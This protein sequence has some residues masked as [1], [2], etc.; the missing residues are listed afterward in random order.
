MRTVY[1]NIDNN[2]DLIEGFGYYSPLTLMAYDDGGLV[3]IKL[4]ETNINI[5][6][7]SYDQY[8][9]EDQTSY[10]ANI[11]EV[12]DNLNIEF[13]KSD[14]LSL[15]FSDVAITFV[16]TNSPSIESQ[17]RDFLR[18]YWK[19]VR[20]Y[21]KRGNPKPLI[22]IIDNATGTLLTL[23]STVVVLVPVKTLSTYLKELIE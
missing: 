18:D 20:Q 10:G 2:R 15:P 23:L 13:E 8:V 16:Q 7:E 1:Y 3:S 4:V 14:N 5:V 9:Y 19:E 6:S 22:N 21:E 11:Q 17:L 12:V